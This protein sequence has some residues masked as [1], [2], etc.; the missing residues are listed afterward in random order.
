MR[1]DEIAANLALPVRTAP[2][3]LE[4]EVTGGYASD[5]LSRVMAKARRGN[6]WVTIQAHPNIVA[7]ASLLELAGIIV[8]EDVELDSVTIEKA[9]E[10]G[11]PILTTEHSTFTIVGSL[12]QLGVA[13]VD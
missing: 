11:I 2:D 13:G 8:A 3:R 5:L 9:N 6:L 4:V 10:E 7:V 1:L 12:V